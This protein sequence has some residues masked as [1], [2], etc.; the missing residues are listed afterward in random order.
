ML[1][2]DIQFPRVN[3]I[4]MIDTIVSKGGDII[5]VIPDLYDKQND[6]V[7]SDLVIEFLD[8]I[9]LSVGDMCISRAE[10]GNLYIIAITKY[11]IDGSI[12]TDTVL[13]SY[14]L[15]AMEYYWQYYNRI[16]TIVDT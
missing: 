3:Y 14:L 12:L 1:Y 13:K 5:N 10:Q 2:S 4:Q 11:A 7:R 15:D 9:P 8:S 16:S 6:F